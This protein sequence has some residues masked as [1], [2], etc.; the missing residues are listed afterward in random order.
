MNSLCWILSYTDKI[1]EIKLKLNWIDKNEIKTITC[2]HLTSERFCWSWCSDDVCPLR[3]GVVK[4]SDGCK[5]RNELVS[6]TPE[7]LFIFEAEFSGYSKSFVQGKQSS[8]NCCIFYQ[9][10]DLLTAYTETWWTWT[11]MYRVKPAQEEIGPS[12]QAT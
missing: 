7:Q 6:L 2:L 5:K 11:W 4:G 8:Y 9:K 1:N 10:L 12:G 3:G